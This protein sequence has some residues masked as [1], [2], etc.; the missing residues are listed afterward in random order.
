MAP[1]T[2]AEAMLMNFLTIVIFAIFAIKETRKNFKVIDL[3]EDKIIR[4]MTWKKKV[5][6]LSKMFY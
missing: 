5:Q 1:F 2:A 6:I 3:E 4:H